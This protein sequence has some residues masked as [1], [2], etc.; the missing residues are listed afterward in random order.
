MKFAQ[1]KKFKNYIYSFLLL[2]KEIQ[3]SVEIFEHFKWSLLKI[4]SSQWMHQ[5]R[6]NLL[7]QCFQTIWLVTELEVGGIV[8]QI[9]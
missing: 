5:I 4:N 9:V 7:H 2:E 3:E 6:W 1:T 8:E